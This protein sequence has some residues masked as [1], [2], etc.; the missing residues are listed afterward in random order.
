MFS[1]YLISFI[2]EIITGIP[3]VEKAFMGPL[4]KDRIAKEEGP[5]GRRDCK[6][7]KVSIKLFS[8]GGGGRLLQKFPLWRYGK[9]SD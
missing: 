6:A 2:I 9:E 3:T 1:S 5:N 7:V 8:S 4:K